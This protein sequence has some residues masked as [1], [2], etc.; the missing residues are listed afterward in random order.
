MSVRAVS[1]SDINYWIG[2]G[3]VEAMLVIAWNDGKTPGA[4]GVGL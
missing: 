1:F 4:V 2:E 3:N